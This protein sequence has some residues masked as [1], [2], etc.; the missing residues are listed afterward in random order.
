MKPFSSKALHFLVLSVKVH[1]E[2]L[3]A[4]LQATE[5][6]DEQADHLNDLHYL[7]CLLEELDER[8]TTLEATL[9]TG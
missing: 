8:Q 6:E 1:I 7:R 5:D 2:K 9:G 3:E 4:A